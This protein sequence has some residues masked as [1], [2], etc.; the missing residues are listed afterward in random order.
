MEDVK[1]IH[2]MIVVVNTTNFDAS[3]H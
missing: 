2:D 3:T 1:K